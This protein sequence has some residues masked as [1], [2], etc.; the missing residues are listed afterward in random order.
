M[1]EGQRGTDRLPF[2]N[3][4]SWLTHGPG[5]CKSQQHTV[6]PL[7]TESEFSWQP[8][9]TDSGI[10]YSHKIKANHNTVHTGVHKGSYADDSR[11]HHGRER[12]HEL[13]Y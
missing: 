2:T 11:N 3:C 7:N 8:T 10:P 13:H 12:V 1:N 4:V 6:K 9:S 5:D